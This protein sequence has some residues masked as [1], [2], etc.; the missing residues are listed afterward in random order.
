MKD[1]IL[2]SGN[3]ESSGDDKKFNKQ[4]KIRVSAMIGINTKYTDNTH[5]CYC[6]G[7][8]KGREIKRQDYKDSSKEMIFDVCLESE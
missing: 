8:P 1:T 5:I 4:L 2:L 6:C 7:N 3:S